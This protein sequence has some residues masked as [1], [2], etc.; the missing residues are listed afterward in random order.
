[1]RFLHAADVHLD[2]PLLGLD[3]YEGAPKEAIR[4]ASRR[5][6]DRLVDLAVSERVSLVLLA[7]D[8]YDGDWRDVR[9]GLFFVARMSRLA[10]A[11]IPVVVISGNHDAESR[12]TGKLPYPANVRVLSAD[13][14]ETFRLEAQR[15]AVHGQ[16]YAHQKENRNLAAA[17]PDPIPGWFNIG[18]LHTAMEGRA[19]HEPYAPC[20]LEELCARGYD[21]WALGHVHRRE[22]VNG[23]N[24]PRVEYPGNLQGRHIRETGP[25][26]CLLV[27][28]DSSGRTEPEFRPLDVF[29]WIARSVDVTGMR[30]VDEVLDAAGA[31]VSDAAGLADVQAAA[32]RIELAGRSP[33]HDAL[34][35]QY[36]SLTDQVRSLALG[37]F[38]GRL[39]LER[40][41]IRTSRE[42]A[43]TEPETVLTED[44]L[45]EIRGVLSDLRSDPRQIAA[46]LEDDECGNLLKKLPPEI[47]WGPDILDPNDEDAVSGLLDRAGSILGAAVA[48]VETPR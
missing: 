10:D 37:E 3:D 16:G 45:S 27:S 41:V 25:K 43:A 42:D 29:R 46:W 23:P 6:L 1:V 32:L 11:G 8:L 33:L 13:R 44:A 48:R 22:S 5:A 15:V 9:T 24:H 20:T 35:A 28:V 39:W 17:Y 34:E 40:L 26:G 31:A 19:G 47:R 38:G 21:Y 36:E 30:S 12:I 7:G 14:P 4:G 2:S 18:L